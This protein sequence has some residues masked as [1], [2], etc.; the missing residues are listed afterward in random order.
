M[1]K[2]T[3]YER[4]ILRVLLRR[5]SWITIKKIADLTGMSW[6]TA[7]KYVKRMYNCGWLRKKGNYW[8]VK[9]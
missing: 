2:L 3:S 4:D 8:K 5:R 9:K 1:V 7:K 6:N